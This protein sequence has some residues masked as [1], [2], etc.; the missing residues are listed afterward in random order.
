MTKR[1]A[2]SR[3]RSAEAV[4]RGAD[5]ALLATVDGS[6][7]VD[8]E[9]D[10][11]GDLRRC[12]EVN[13]GAACAARAGVRQISDAR[14]LTATRSRSD[15]EDLRHLEMGSTRSCW[16]RALVPGDHQQAKQMMS[17]SVCVICSGAR[18]S[19]MQ[20]AMRSATEDVARPRAKPARRLRRQNR[21]DWAMILG[22]QVTSRAT[23]A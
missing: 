2:P 20:A 3:R 1:P 18:G 5:T 16:R 19:A 7:I 11:L 6:T 23:A 21:V 12:I 8:V 22:R 4:R 15:G 9:G 14:S 10:A 17:A 13:H